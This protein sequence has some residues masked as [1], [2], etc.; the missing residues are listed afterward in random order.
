VEVLANRIDQAFTTP[1]DAA[2]TLVSITASV[3]IAF[4]GRGHQLTDHLVST[5][6]AAMYQAKRKG[7]ARHQIIDLREVSRA[8]ERRDLERDLH[9]AIAHDQLELH[10]QPVVKSADGL[11]TG[12]EALLR[13]KHPSYGP[14]PPQK[15]IAIAEEIGL[16]ADV[17]RWVLERACREH[18]KWQAKFPQQLCLGVN[19]SATQLMSPN[20]PSIVASVLTA[21]TTDPSTLILEMT[22][23]IFIADSE[24]AGTALHD[25]KGLGVNVALDDFGTGYSSLSYL[26]K[27]PVDVLKID[28]TFLVNLVEDPAGTVFLAAVTNLAHALGLSV[29][30]EGVE[31][32]QQAAV[33][34]AVGCESSQGFYY[35]RPMPADQIANIM[36]TGTS[37]PHLPMTGTGTDR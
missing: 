22:E 27:F 24:R 17:G 10:Y 6:D 37:T 20:F 25:L 9:T 5:A 31:T 7:G 11:V 26:R 33:V 21:T 8:T 18:H 28:Q 15:L 35:A 1:F 36:N 23:D 16:I 34:S 14:I 19:V 2:G 4:A 3:G 13:W 30:A 32:Q 12:V 29:T